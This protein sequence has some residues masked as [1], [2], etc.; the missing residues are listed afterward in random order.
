MCTHIWVTA[1]SPAPCARHSHP[2][3]PSHP[4][5][6][7]LAHDGDRKKTECN[8]SSDPAIPVAR[9]P[10]AG[11]VCRGASETGHHDGT[12]RNY[13]AARCKCAVECLAELPSPGCPAPCGICPNNPLLYAVFYYSLPV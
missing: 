2:P 7:T 4:H 13:W 5:T 11:R 6:T 9:A 10:T 1:S 3:N 8:N 12:Q